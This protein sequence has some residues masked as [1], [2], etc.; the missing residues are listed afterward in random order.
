MVLPCICEICEQEKKSE[1]SPGMEGK[2]ICSTK[3][4]FLSEKDT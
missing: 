1:V 4:Q 3:G 2:M